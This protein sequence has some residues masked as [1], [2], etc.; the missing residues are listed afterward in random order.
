M[1][2][3]NMKLIV[4]SREHKMIEYIRGQTRIVFGKVDIS[5][6]IATIPAGDFA[7]CRCMSADATNITN[8]AGIVDGAS[9]GDQVLAILE[10]KTLA[11]Y[12]ASIVDKRMDNIEGMLKARAMSGCDLYVLI[13][14]NSTDTPIRELAVR[15]NM[16]KLIRKP[17]EHATNI[18]RL[19]GI[20]VLNSIQHLQTRDKIFVDYTLNINGTFLKLLSLCDSY[21]DQSVSV[22]SKAIR[23]GLT[24]GHIFNQIAEGRKLSDSEILERMFIVIPGITD[25]NISLFRGMSFGELVRGEFGM[26][27]IPTRAR[28]EAARIFDKHIEKMLLVIPGI[29]AAYLTRCCES[30]EFCALTAS[31]RDFSGPAAGAALP[32]NTETG[33]NAVS[34]YRAFLLDNCDSVVRAVGSS[35]AAASRHVWELLNIVRV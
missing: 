7:I 2:F 21:R 15:C 5:I 1:S 19:P 6:E 13:E 4:D 33:A 28:N 27:P 16:A 20:N 22:G 11:D 9:C 12:S 8:F 26:R 34:I 30:A 32:S 25:S 23:G 29:T 14:E 18:G 24:S 35:K 31:L 10:R 17:A 3:I